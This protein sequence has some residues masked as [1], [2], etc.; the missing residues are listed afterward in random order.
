M[1]LFSE[2]TRRKMS[3]EEE[4]ARLIGEETEDVS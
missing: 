4:I 3:L 1:K 2:E